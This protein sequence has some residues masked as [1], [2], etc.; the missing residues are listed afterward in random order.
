M[1][2]NE[3][4]AYLNFYD[5]SAN[6]DRIV[7]SQLNGGGFESDNHAVAE[8]DGPP[9][10][11]IINTPEPTQAGLLLLAGSLAAVIGLRRKRAN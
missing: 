9:G 3:Q 1:D 11:T 5:S 10:G 8:L 6:F 7:F 4:F 2:N